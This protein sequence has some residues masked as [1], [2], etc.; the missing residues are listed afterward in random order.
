M[1]YI[2]NAGVG[3]FLLVFLGMIPMAY[4]NGVESAPE[5]EKKGFKDIIELSGQ[6]NT[7]YN[8]NFNNPT[9]AA[10]TLR[11]FDV[12][13]NDFDFNLFD[14]VI[15]AQPTDWANFR[16]DINAGEDVAVVDATKGGVIGADEFGLQQAFVELTAPWGNGLTFKVGHFVTLLGHEVIESASNW[17]TSRGLH[18]GFSIP[19]T[20][21]GLLMTYP[22][23]DN[24]STTIGVING[25]DVVADNNK[26]K[27]VIAQVA[28]K[29]ADNLT[30]A[31]QG[32]FGP[33]QAGS[34][35]N[36]RGIIDFVL[37]WSPYDNWTLGL[38]Y[39]LGKEEGVGGNGFANWHGAAIY[40]HWK[41]LEKFGWT[42][43][44]E[45]FQDDGSRTTFANLDLFEVT[46]TLHYY[47]AD[48]WDLRLELRHDHA[49]S[50]NSIFAK[51][52][53]TTRRFQ[54]TV[55]TEIVYSF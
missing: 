12:T 5:T 34:D 14:L 18:F 30:L 27:S 50:A 16:V 33:E 48:G 47:P 40:S 49:D 41:P 4:A 29:P 26:G 22:W 36:M 19:F 55:S 1:Q 13:H 51:S 23:S 31:V 39:D 24:W 54:D 21:T 52:D 37:D 45:Y 46:N 10:N 28:G 38:N 43:R 32:I 9:P 8:Y 20:H 42:V 2:K 53:G 11:V 35:G 17:N 25:W 3:F 44:G 15:Q 7:S 6:F